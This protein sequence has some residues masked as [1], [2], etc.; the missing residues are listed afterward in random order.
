MDIGSA[1]PP[2]WSGG[3]PDHAYY[4]CLYRRIF[5]NRIRRTS[6]IRRCRTPSAVSFETFSCR[7]P[8]IRFRG[9]LGA[10]LAEAHAGANLPRERM[11]LPTGPGC[12]GFRASSMGL[13]SPTFGSTPLADVVRAQAQ[14]VRE[15]G[16]RAVMEQGGRKEKA[17]MVTSVKPLPV[18]MGPGVTGVAACPAR[19][20]G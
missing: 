4:N 12:P 7:P 8:D 14:D 9:A 19:A 3:R 17:M 18:Q 2:T 11:D 1:E 6:V 13:S 16:R 5:D 10:C 15:S 20:I